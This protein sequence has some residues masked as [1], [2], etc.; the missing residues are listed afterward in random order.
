LSSIKGEDAMKTSVVARRAVLGLLMAIVAGGG[1]LAVQAAV[2]PTNEFARATID[3]GVVV[4]DL[5]R[6]VK[7]YTEAIGFKEIQGFSV[8][9]DFCAN[10]GLTDHKKLDIRVLVLGDEASA[11]RL[12]LM[13]VPSVESKKSDNTFIHSQ[14]GYS[15]LTV[16][17]ADGNRA[18]ERLG[19]AGVRPLAKGPV[20]LPADLTPGLALTVV[21]DPDGNLIELIGPVR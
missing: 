14:L 1:W 2:A 7:F 6:A 19:R 15:Y 18:L 5:D 4:R 17:V 20:P 11:T 21:R 12:K 9:A 10:A 3:I 8:D 13:E 16:Y